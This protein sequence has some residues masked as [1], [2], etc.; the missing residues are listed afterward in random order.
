MPRT[1]R[2]QW[3]SRVAAAVVVALATAAPAVAADPFARFDLPDEWE[4]RFWSGEGAKA[5]FRLDPRAASA[6]V[7]A[8]AGVRFCRCPACDAD[9]ADDPLS[10][11][12]ALPEKL[13]CRRCGVVVP[14][15][16]YPAPDEKDKKVPEEAVEVRPGVTHHYPYHAVEPAAQ[17]YPDERLYLAAKRDYE[18]R[19]FLAQ[20]ALYAAVRYRQGPPGRADPKLAAVAGAILVRCAQ[21][22]PAYAT[23]YDQPNSLKFFERADPPPPY[24]RGY[25]TGKWDWNAGQDVPLNLVVA[26][27]L[28][29]DDGAIKEAGRLLGE[30]DP[31]G[32]VERDLF[33]A[34]AGFV[35]RQADESGEASLPGYRG[36]LAVGRLL[37]DAPMVEETVARLARFAEQGFYYDGFWRQGTLT[38]HRRVVGQLDGWI[39]RLLA[40]ASGVAPSPSPRP[41]RAG[42]PVLNLA[43][44][45]GSAVLHDPS[46]P[47]VRL[48]SWPA[49]AG[50]DP[51]RTPRLL[52]GVG[53]ARLALGRGPDA[54]DVELRSLDSASPGRVRRQAL[55]LA[56][57]GR[58]VLDDLDES[59]GVPS[60]FDRA[61]ASR[62]TVAVDGLNQRESLATADEP[63]AGGAFLFF[64]ADP[65]F[66][67]VVLDDPRAYPR[68]TTRYR[69]TVVASAG[70]RSRYALGVFEVTGGTRHDQFFHG[71]AGSAA[72]WRLSR[73]TAPGP[74]TLLP[75]GLTVVPQA[76]ADDDRWF[77]Q[78]L[79][80]F[81][82]LA[83]SPLDRPAQ[84]WLAGADGPPSVRLH[85]LGDAPMTA[86]T[87]VTPD[88]TDASGRGSLVL[89]RRSEDGSALR[90][91]YV[92][93]FEPV[94][95]SVPPLVRVGRVKSAPEVV[96]VSVA[97]AEGPE[98]LVVNLRPGTMRTL[99]LADGRTLTTD[100]VAVRVRGDALVLAGG[101]YAGCG[102]RV[103][104]SKAV[105][106]RVTDVVRRGGPS[107]DGRGWFVTDAPLPAP[108][109]LSGRVML[110]RHGDGTT[111][112]W[113]LTRVENLENGA[114]LHVREEPGIRL[115]GRERDAEFYHYP[116]TTLPGPHELRVS[117][118]AR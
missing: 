114:R 110:V 18:A 85:L 49:P 19:E 35:R 76:R 109:T 51:P 23:H 15:D 86:V 50:V 6:L 7:P 111:H 102:G 82:D 100:G 98:H 17:R 101:S 43:R 32:A 54:L 69:Q 74:E 59:A 28:L 14:N 97:T 2:A 89:R 63:A 31:A 29:R 36:V 53:L 104:R 107:G 115:V 13:T 103:V 25:R 91:V 117:L 60:G 66:Q 11:S 67:A 55:R 58:N 33:R 88:P 84:A 81:R 118:I 16:K 68:S 45:A 62:N 70:A 77:V 92:T 44:G 106:G 24:R 5:L 73:P 3:P 37:D 94:T 39:G 57:G 65:D 75:P 21:V 90:T 83:R 95:G 34:S 93:L 61:T 27:A 96:V 30:P 1:S 12:A 105:G 87:A 42:L 48:A 46:P 80:E 112:G 72:R 71:P 26:Y 47:E 10:W 38:A 116:R 41:D 78:A 40:G 79:G 4:S 8:Q 108:E 99:T 56:V 9:E 20:A 64:A 22:Y 52:G 113:T